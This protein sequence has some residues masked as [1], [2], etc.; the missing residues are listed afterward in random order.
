MG[1]RD[2]RHVRWNWE[3]SPETEDMSDNPKLKYHIIAV[4]DRCR[5]GIIDR[6]LEPLG[7]FGPLTQTRTQ[8]GTVQGTKFRYLFET[9]ETQIKPSMLELEKL[10]KLIIRDKKLYERERGYIEDY[11]ARMYEENK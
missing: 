5:R 2:Q 9:Y 10:G 1:Y 4:D 7:E 8:K 11:V 3:K 6:I